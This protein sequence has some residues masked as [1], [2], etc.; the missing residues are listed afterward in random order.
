V[1][2]VKNPELLRMAKV[3]SNYY[4]LWL[5]TTI[6]DTSY[7]MFAMF[8]KCKLESNKLKLHADGFLGKKAPFCY[9]FL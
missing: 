2:C 4:A 1:A 7:L 6:L 8:R 5:I 9:F 3:W